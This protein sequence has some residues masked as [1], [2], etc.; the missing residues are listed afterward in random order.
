MAVPYHIQLRISSQY[1]FWIHTLT[2]KSISPCSI[3]TFPAIMALS[4]SSEGSSACRMR[5]CKA[6]GQAA[7]HSSQ[8]WAYSRKTSSMFGKLVLCHPAPCSPLTP[9]VSQNQE[10]KIWGS[11]VG[12][13]EQKSTS[14]IL[15]L[16]TFCLSSSLPVVFPC[17]IFKN[18]Y[19]QVKNVIRFWSGNRQE[20]NLPVG[21]G[22]SLGI[23]GEFEAGMK[24]HRKRHLAPEHLAADTVSRMANCVL[25]CT[26]HNIAPMKYSCQKIEH[27]WNSSCTAY[28]LS[29]K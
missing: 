1:L 17:G 20:L 26:W 6:L 25:R 11:A 10:F 5:V 2:V 7:V 8:G 29:V 27:I 16:Y 18:P 24:C 28:L 13:K 19:T 23:W 9:A 12:S 3:P 14:D 22:I 15:A 21:V 4:S